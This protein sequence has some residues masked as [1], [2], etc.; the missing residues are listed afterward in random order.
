[1]CVFESSEVDHCPSCKWFY[2]H[3][4]KLFERSRTFAGERLPAASTE[5]LRLALDQEESSLCSCYLQQLRFGSV[6]GGD[7]RHVHC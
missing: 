2:S 6:E 1:M 3:L 4:K 5:A 7:K